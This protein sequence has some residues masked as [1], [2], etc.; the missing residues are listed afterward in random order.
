MQNRADASPTPAGSSEPTTSPSPEQ[1]QARLFDGCVRIG[2]AIDTVSYKASDGTRLEGVTLGQGRVGILLGHQVNSN[3]CEWFPFARTLAE[4]GF[5]VLAFD[6][7]GNGSSYPVGGD[8]GRLDLDI[9]AGV[10]Q[11]MR[12]GAEEVVVIGASMGGTAAVVA[13]ASPIDGLAGVISMSGPGVFADL[14]AGAAARKLDVPVLY[15]AGRAD[16]TF[17]S[18]ARR[19]YQKTRSPDKELMIVPGASHGSLML[20]PPEEPGV[21]KAILSFIEGHTRR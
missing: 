11:L 3:V 16:G 17:A 21:R 9:P 4:Q 7:R 14:D 15:L 5:R 19:M 10:E 12:L 2:G 1:K 18:E 13:G 6:F 20:L 8:P